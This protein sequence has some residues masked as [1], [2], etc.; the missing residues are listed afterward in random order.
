MA[1]KKP[2]SEAKRAANKKW[3]DANLT[4]RYDRIQLVVPKG[5][6]EVIQEA[7]KINNESVNG[8]M[9]RLLLAELDRLRA[10]GH[11][12]NIVS[13]GGDGFGLEEM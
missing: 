5:Q 3:N 13:G 4:K 1:E 11:D 2:M 6:R 8:M 10:A 12:L 9:I 7:A